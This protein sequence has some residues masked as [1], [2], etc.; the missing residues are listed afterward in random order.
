MSEA[1]LVALC[2]LV[3]AVVSIV[4]SRFKDAEIEKLKGEIAKHQVVFQVQYESERRVYRE[5]WVAARAFRDAAAVELESVRCKQSLETHREKR[6]AAALAGKAFVDGFTDEWPFLPPGVYDEA[7]RFFDLVT[8]ARIGA[9]KTRVE[10]LITNKFTGE[11]EEWPLADP[12]KIEPALETLGEAI[13]ARITTFGP[14]DR[15]A[16]SDATSRGLIGKVFGLFR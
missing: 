10:V 9:L 3:S 6:R 13:R 4:P 2:A 5:I 8:G 14:N 11:P 15:P 12:G 1:I 16:V 7:K